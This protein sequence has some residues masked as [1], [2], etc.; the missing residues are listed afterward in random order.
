MPAPV[1][2]TPSTDYTDKEKMVAVREMRRKKRSVISI[3]R[4]LGI[5]RQTLYAWAREFPMPVNPDDAFQLQNLK[6]NVLQLTLK[7]PRQGLKS[8]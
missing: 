1:V 4:E 8:P 7:P 3:A 6:L 5:S 2:F